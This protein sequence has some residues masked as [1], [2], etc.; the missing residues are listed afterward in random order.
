MMRVLKII[1]DIDI[2]LE[3]P[4]DAHIETVKMD[5]YMVTEYEERFDMIL[6]VHTL[7]TLWAAQIGD[8]VKKLVG[9]L[10]HRGELQIHVPATE[11]AAK[12]LIKD[13]TDPIAFYMIWGTE[14]RP[15]HTGFTLMWLRAIIE[16]SGAIVRRAN[17][18]LFNFQFNEVEVRAPEHVVTATVDRD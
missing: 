15:F 12:A 3:L 9:D 2:A 14:K 16:Q 7:Q 8:A 1:G 4:E 11:H 6:C 13:E 5:D 10:A 18:G 17:I